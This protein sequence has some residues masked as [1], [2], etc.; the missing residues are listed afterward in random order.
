MKRQRRFRARHYTSMKSA[1]KHLQKAGYALMEPLPVYKADSLN[2]GETTN[3][4]LFLRMNCVLPACTSLV[5]VRKTYQHPYAKGRAGFPVF[6]EEIQ[7]L[8]WVEHKH[9]RRT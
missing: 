7:F 6:A 4:Y 3:V 2:Q 1:F 5:A 9:E 8:P